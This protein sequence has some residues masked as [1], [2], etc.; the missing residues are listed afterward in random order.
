MV[1]LEAGEPLAGYRYDGKH[2]QVVTTRSVDRS[3]ALPYRQTDS[4]VVA[5]PP[6]DRGPF[7]HGSFDFYSFV[8]LLTFHRPTF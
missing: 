4:C 3:I 6:A 8:D 5:P 1:S 2:V 7:V